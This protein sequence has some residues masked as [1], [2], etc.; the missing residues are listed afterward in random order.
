M[1]SK[2]ERPRKLSEKDDGF[3]EDAVDVDDELPRDESADD[4]S[5]EVDANDSESRDESR[6]KGWSCFYLVCSSLLNWLL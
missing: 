2:D 4:I 3:A 1:I 6:K 5:S